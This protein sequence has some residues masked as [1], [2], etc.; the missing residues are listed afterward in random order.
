MDTILGGLPIFD[1]GCGREDPNAWVRRV[2]D[3]WGIFGVGG[4]PTITGVFTRPGLMG[5]CALEDLPF[6][7]P[8]TASKN[9]C[10]E[11]NWAS[12]VSAAASDAIITGV[13]LPS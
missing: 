1:M 7:S 3:P 8:Y 5:V 12:D 10:A 6:G 2:G 13:M 9:V 11:N 4:F